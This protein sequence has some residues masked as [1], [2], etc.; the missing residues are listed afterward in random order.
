LFVAELTPLLRSRLL[1]GAGGQTTSRRLSHFFHQCEI[2]VKAGTLIAERLPHDNSSPL[3]GQ[4]SN[5]L[6]FFG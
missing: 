1:Q 3:F 5:R 2:D 4:S 6:Q